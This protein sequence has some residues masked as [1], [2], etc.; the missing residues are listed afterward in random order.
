MRHRSPARDGRLA[1]RL[2]KQSN[3]R[4]PSSTNSVARSIMY[5]TPALECSQ[6][7]NAFCC[8]RRTRANATR[9]RVACARHAA[10][11][12]PNPNPNTASAGD[13][14][15]AVDFGHSSSFLVLFFC[16]LVEILVFARV[17][18][19]RIKR[20]HSLANPRTWAANTTS[21]SLPTKPRPSLFR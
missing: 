15:H 4:T 7:V 1:C 14:E 8:I 12:S 16:F 17:W 18:S 19:G 10:M 2:N 3:H 13:I 21:P 11:R 20:S 5:R 6:Q 9:R